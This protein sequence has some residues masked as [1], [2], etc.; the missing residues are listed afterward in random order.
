MELEHPD[1]TN[2]RLAGYPR[3]QEPPRTERWK[4]KSVTH[5]ESFLY[6]YE[7]EET[8]ENATT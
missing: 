5:E 8:D 6:K 1:I 2:A 4:A 3:G 7:N